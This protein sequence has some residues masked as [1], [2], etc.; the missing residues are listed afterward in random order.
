MGLTDAWV[1][2]SDTL[3]RVPTVVADANEVVDQARRGL[4]LIITPLAIFFW[5]A[6]AI[7]VRDVF[8][9]DRHQDIA[10][11]AVWSAFNSIVYVLAAAALEPLVKR[12]PSV[13][14]DILGRITAVGRV[15]AAAASALGGREWVHVPEINVTSVE[16]GEWLLVSRD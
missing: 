12:L 6:V 1:S 7:V 4:D 2:A 15:T 14:Q 5:L 3:R 11:Q 10:S 9:G 8:Y 16:D 13:K